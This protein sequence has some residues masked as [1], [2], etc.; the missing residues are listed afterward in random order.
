MLGFRYHLF[1]YSVFSPKV[2]YDC[3]TVLV[4]YLVF[5]VTSLYFK[6]FKH[7]A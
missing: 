3:Y 7:D 5:L 2:L 1:I 4:F 6:L